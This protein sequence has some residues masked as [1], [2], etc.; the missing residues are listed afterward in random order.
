MGAHSTVFIAK[1]VA[2]RLFNEQVGSDQEVTTKQLEDFYD[3]VLDDHL[4]NCRLVADDSKDL[5][6]SEFGTHLPESLLKDYLI[7]Y[8]AEHPGERAT[9]ITVEN[10]LLRQMLANVYRGMLTSSTI[11]W[12]T[13]SVVDLK[14]KLDEH[15]DG[16]RRLWE[17]R[18]T[19][20]RG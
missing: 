5:E 3:R 12:E 18:E 2:R 9:S 6:Y 10:A 14:R 16:A 15:Y 20:L 17:A 4:Y 11:N 19:N 7:E 1:T 8:V 13:D